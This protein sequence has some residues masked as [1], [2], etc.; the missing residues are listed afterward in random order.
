MADL[1]GTGSGIRKRFRDLEPGNADANN[2]SFAQYVSLGPVTPMG[3]SEY[4]VGP[5]AVPLSSIPLGAHRMHVYNLWTVDVFW[6]D[7]NGDTPTASH[8]FPLKSDAWLL[9]DN[10]PSTDFKMLGPAGSADVRV[11]YY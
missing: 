7:V 4:T 9:Y 10:D 11:A 1:E 5:S 8:G 6:T 2:K 3:H